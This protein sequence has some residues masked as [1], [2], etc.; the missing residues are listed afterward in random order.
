MQFETTL[1]QT[2]RNTGIEVPAEVVEALGGGRRAP[3]VVTVNG[4]EYR[5]TLAVMGGRHLIPFSSDKRAATG[6]SGGDPIS[7]ELELDTAPRTVEPPEDFAA[8]LDATP[9]AREAFDR[10]APSHRKAHVNA[11]ME[12]KAPETRARRIAK[13]VEQLAGG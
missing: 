2:G 4:Y 1:S 10:L 9:G 5:S 12:A 8:A 3:V 6:L 13:A 11:I 7:V